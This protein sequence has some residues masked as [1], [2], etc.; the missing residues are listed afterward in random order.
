MLQKILKG[1][2]DMLN[3]DVLHRND[4]IKRNTRLLIIPNQLVCCN[5]LEKQAFKL[6]CRCPA[7]KP[8]LRTSFPPTQ[9]P[10]LSAHRVVAWMRGG[11]S[12]PSPP[13]HLLHGVYPLI[14][15]LPETEAKQGREECMAKGHSDKLASGLEGGGDGR[16]GWEGC[17]EIHGGNR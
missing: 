11:G 3:K 14:G 6:I 9:T 5:K 2:K 1:L 7:C 15:P 17:M 8:H 10:S 16:G 12:C 4:G 13:P